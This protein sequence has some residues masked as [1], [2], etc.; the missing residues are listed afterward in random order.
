[1]L[2]KSTDIGS[3][4][5]SPARFQSRMMQELVRNETLREKELLW[6]AIIL[7]A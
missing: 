5:L 2:S 1:V 4:P 7:I 3:S 6:D